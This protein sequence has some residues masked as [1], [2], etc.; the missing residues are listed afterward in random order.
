MPVEVEAEVMVKVKP[1][2]V[3][4]EVGVEE[5]LLQVVLPATLILAVAG[6]VADQ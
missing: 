3:V 6:A 2:Q 1:L 5:D 4:A